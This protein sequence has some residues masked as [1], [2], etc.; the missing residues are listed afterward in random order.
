MGVGLRHF[1]DSVLFPL[2]PL[3]EAEL[4][5]LDRRGVVHSYLYLM[6]LSL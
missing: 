3:E 2:L 4:D 5:E 6:V 1:A